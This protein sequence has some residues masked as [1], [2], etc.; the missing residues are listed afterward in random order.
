MHVYQNI[1][2]LFMLC[3]LDT[4]V[5]VIANAVDYLKP[6]NVETILDKMIG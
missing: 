1:I 6:L 5:H 2:L 4:N 3:Q